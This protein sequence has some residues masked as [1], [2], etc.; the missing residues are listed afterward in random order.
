MQQLC[1]ALPIEP[2]KIDAARAFGADLA[3]TRRE[4]HAAFQRR[5]GIMRESWY[6]QRTAHGHLLLLYLESHDLHHTLQALA[7]PG[8]PYDRWFK[9][10]VAEIVGVDVRDALSRPGPEHLFSCEVPQLQLPV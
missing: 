10:R 5:T 9:A 2:G 4:E 1:Y 7:T 6:L 8:G 3:G